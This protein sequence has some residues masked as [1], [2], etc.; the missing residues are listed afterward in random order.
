[1]SLDGRITIDAIFHD[2]AGTAAVNVVSLSDSTEYT[3]GKVAVITGTC[4]TSAVL[5]EP[6]AYEYRGADGQITMPSSVPMRVGF[7]ASNWC[8]LTNP[9]DGGISVL[10]SGSR[11]STT[12]YFSFANE[13]YVNVID[14]GVTGQTSSYTILLY[15]VG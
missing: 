2:T 14:L 6:S 11:V 13:L 10:S 1:M 9:E 15:G 4:G 7:A 3:A 12:E 5:I 8:R